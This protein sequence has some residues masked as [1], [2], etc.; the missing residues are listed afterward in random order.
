[1]FKVNFHLH[2]AKKKVYLGDNERHWPYIYFDFDFH[3]LR[4]EQQFIQ[5]HNHD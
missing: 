4:T 5:R 1:M 3:A 2:K